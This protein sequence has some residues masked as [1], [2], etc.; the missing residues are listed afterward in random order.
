MRH[1]G[2]REAGKAGLTT[3][4]FVTSAIQLHRCEVIICQLFMD[5]MLKPLFAEVFGFRFYG[6]IWIGLNR[7][8]L[9]SDVP[10]GQPGTG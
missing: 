8:L 5:K 10:G 4:R 2:F 7:V 3:H 6:V 1:T 9:P